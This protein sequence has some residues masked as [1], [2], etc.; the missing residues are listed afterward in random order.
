[1]KKISYFLLIALV[2]SAC[3][4][5][6]KLNFENQR[7]ETSADAVIVINYPKAVGTK[8]VVEKIN[9]QIEHVIANDMNMAETTENNISVK[10]AVA[11]FDDEYKLFKKDF[12]D[13]SQKWEVKVDGSVLYETAEVVSISLRSYID[14]G[15]AHGNSR[16]TYLNFNPETG[17]LLEENDIISNQSEFK[18]IAE[19]AFKEQATPED[20]GETIEDFFFGEDF[21][22]PANIGFT[23]EGL[24]LL[25][26]N[27]E[28][29]AYTQGAT[30]IVLPYADLK[31]VLKIN[32]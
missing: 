30:K 23:K 25:Y 29:A 20:E 3:N 5:D 11:Q 2:I 19:K 26:N 1:M 21:Q 28:I 12:Q 18:V 9:Q 4:E 32:P 7:I 6:V 31:G 14:T 15:G 27:Y 17:A 16:L 8:A 24:V 10:E 22:L 13:T